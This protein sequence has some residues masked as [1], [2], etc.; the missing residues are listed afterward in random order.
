MSGL[1]EHRYPP[2]E[3][4][5]EDLC[6]A[7]C[8][9]PVPDGPDGRLSTGALWRL[10]WEVRPDL[11]FRDGVRRVCATCVRATVGTVKAREPEEGS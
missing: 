3:H 9:R 10:G 7:G 2:Y 6:D 8:G 4:G 5:W 11:T 1:R